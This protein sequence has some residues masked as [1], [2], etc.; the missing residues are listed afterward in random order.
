MFKTLA[1]TA[2]TFI[3][4]SLSVYDVSAQDRSW[5]KKCPGPVYASSEVTRRARIVEGPDFSGVM[6]VFRNVNGRIRLDA[7]L[8]RSGEVT[9]IHVTDGLSATVNEFVSAAV[10]M[11][12]FV[13]AELNLHS[14]SQ[15]IQFEFEINDGQVKEVAR[16][17]PAGRVVE[18]VD[19][20]GYRRVTKEDIFGWI[21]TRPGNV[22]NPDLVKQDLKAIL[23]TGYFNAIGTRVTVEDA[24]RGGV[25]V[26]FDVVELPLIAE[27]RFE[28]LKLSDQSAVI[29]ELTKQ[30]V[31]VRN[32][33]PFDPAKLKIAVNVIEQFFQSQGWINVKVEAF[34]ENLS[35]TEVKVVFKISGHNL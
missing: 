31:D 4:F 5:D 23:A 6:E 32:D 19:F 34:I 20:I 12:R 8:C 21:L 10:S 35:P 24:V 7:V 13:P 33:R 15:K 16:Q 26:I 2:F 28:G 29:N 9:D 22:Y 3:L 18:E 25:R 11:V 14:V 1:I 27:V 17:P 30:R